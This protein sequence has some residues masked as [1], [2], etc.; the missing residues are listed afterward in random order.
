MKDPLNIL[1][2]AQ[3]ASTRFG[4]E[5]IIP[6]HYFREIK[7]LGHN[8]MMVTHER[9]RSDILDYFQGSSDGIFF[10]KDTIFHRFL[11]IMGRFFPKRVG[12]LFFGTILNL[13]DEFFQNRIIAEIVKA[14]PIEV[15]H[16]P[17]PVSPNAPSSIFGFGIPV[18]IGPLNGGMSYPEGWENLE[19]RIERWTLVASR[20]IAPIL[21]RLVPGKAKAAILLV[22]NERTH[23]ALPIKHR[24]VRVLVENGVDYETFGQLANVDQ[25]PAGS[26]RLVYMGRLVAWKAVNVT[27]EA[28]CMVR[29]QGV[30]VRFDI[31]GD[32]PERGQLERLTDALDLAEVVNFHGF[33]PQAECADILRKSDALILNSVYECGGAVV[34]EAMAIGLPTIVT[35]WGGPMDYVDRSTG[36]LVD[37]VP[38]ST[39]DRRLAEAIMQ[40][41]S[42]PTVRTALGQAGAERTFQYYNWEEKGK[43]MINIYGCAISSTKQRSAQSVLT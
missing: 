28:V 11:W 10:T 43:Q 4:G 23:K 40:L 9:N 33:K 39:F 29:R 13:F 14:R 19:T 3:N 35:N 30:D 25:S 31:V 21:N 36:I 32:G 42:D 24:D 1:I 41:A 7:R 22:A 17:I 38:R 26:I 37:P 12:E 8:V 34:L 18:V 16:Q 20:A 6:I 15:I 27:L 5:A 2:V